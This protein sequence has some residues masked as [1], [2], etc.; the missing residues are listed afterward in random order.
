MSLQVDANVVTEFTWDY[1]QR[2]PALEKLYEKGKT[3]Q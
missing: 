1:V 2:Q 3:S